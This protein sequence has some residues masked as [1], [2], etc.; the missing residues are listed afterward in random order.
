MLPSIPCK[1]LKKVYKIVYDGLVYITSVLIGVANYWLKWT[2]WGATS[3]IIV[4]AGFLY[5]QELD[6]AKLS[7]CIVVIRH[8]RSIVYGCMQTMEFS[9]IMNSYE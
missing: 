2:C 6:T 4:A 9:V 5:F 7:S 8:S 1:L 3:H